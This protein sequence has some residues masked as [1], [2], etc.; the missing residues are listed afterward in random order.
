MRFRFDN[1]RLDAS[2]RR[3]TCDGRPV[4]LAPKA[5]TLL[6][7]LISE[8]PRAMAKRELMEHVWPDVI[9]EE[10]NLKN[11]IAEVRAALGDDGRAEKLIRTV[12]RF[13]YAFTGRVVEEHDEAIRLCTLIVGSR[14]IDVRSEQ[15]VI[16]R[17]RDCDVVISDRSASRHHARIFQTSGHVYLEDLKSK[18]GTWMGGARISDA[19]EL[20][21]GAEFRVGDVP[22]TVV[23]A[24]DEASTT[25]ASG[26]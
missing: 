12:H 24:F 8:R 21:D 22:V 20:R 16:G 14:T 2:E 23:L 19:I 26:T 25:T 18:N 15:A 17:G 9:V 1:Y 4:H 10:A 11:L 3:L 13:G 7:I 6:S 5:F